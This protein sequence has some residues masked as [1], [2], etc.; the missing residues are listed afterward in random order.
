MS[1]ATQFQFDLLD[2]ARLLAKEQG[3]K[4]GYWTIGV[5]FN[6][7]AINAGP[8]KGSMRPSAFVAVD[9]LVLSK[10]D[11]GEQPLTVD[12]SKLK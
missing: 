7:A 1:N 2:V 3:I 11:N 9:Q 4:D 10:A 5:K 8:D 12:A 6:F